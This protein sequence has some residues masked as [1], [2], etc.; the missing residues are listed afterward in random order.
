[1]KTLFLD[2]QMRM[3][4]GMVVLPLRCSVVKTT[5]AL[6]LI[7]PIDF[8]SDQFAQ[9]DQLGEVTDI[10]APSMLHHLHVSTA[11]A[12]YPKASLWAAPGLD[13]KEPG[14]K[15]DRVFGRDPWPYESEIEAVVLEGIPVMN[16]VS[17]LL[18]SLKSLVVVDLVFNLTLPKGWA[19]PVMLR[20]LGTYKRFA[21]SRLV[22]K[23]VRDKEA[24]AR[25][26]RKILA[27]DFDEVVMAHG[28]IIKTGGKKLLRQAFAEK[29]IQ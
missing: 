17:F 9:I 18:K 11:S 25:S 23:S 26:G 15:W 12:R 16:E 10:V 1:M 13:E 5:T 21:I 4:A 27:L 29:G 8:T 6:I 20:M 28:E 3:P 22:T 19:A 2:S 24:F 7:S 14:V